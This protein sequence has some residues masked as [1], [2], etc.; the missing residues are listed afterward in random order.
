MAR[1]ILATN[2]LAIIITL[3][4]CTESNSGRG[5]IISDRMRQKTDR[6]AIIAQADDKEVDIIED[7]ALHR[8]AYR[9]SL[10]ALIKHYRQAGDYMK[11]QWAKKELA[12]LDAIAQYN[13]IIEAHVAGPDLKAAQEIPE[14]DDL[15]YEALVVEDEARKVP[16]IKNKELLRRALDKYNRLIR[17]YPNSD[18]IDDAA[19]KAAIIYNDFKD[20]S[21]ALL[22]FQRVYQWDAESVYPA[23]FKA[24]RLLDR[25]LVRR[26][27]A[28][29]LYQESLRYDPLT[30]SQREAIETR[31]AELN[32]SGQPAR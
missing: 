14:A 4:G 9:Q 31:I 7:M 28:L 10:E 13:Y 30:S 3:T 1:L 24:A 6:H 5:Q 11:R 22:Y 15:Y 27:E 29:K 2:L 20:Y 17:Q 32:Q 21:I 12:A 23:R 16:L 25:K 19:Y 18:K 26:V 8:R